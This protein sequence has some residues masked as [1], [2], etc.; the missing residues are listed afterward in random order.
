MVQKA[1]TFSEKLEFT[2]QLPW[3]YAKK[4]PSYHLSIAD[5]FGHPV[6]VGLEEGSDVEA[7]N[8]VGHLVFK[9]EKEAELLIRVKTFDIQFSSQKSPV[10]LIVTPNGLEH[11][12]IPAHNYDLS[13]TL[14]YRLMITNKVHVVLLDTVLCG[15]GD[16]KFPTQLNLTVQTTDKS[17]DDYFNQFQYTATLEDSA[18]YICTKSFARGNLRLCLRHI[19]DIKKHNLGLDFYRLSVEGEEQFRLDQAEELLKKVIAD[20][21]RLGTYTAGT[22]EFNEIRNRMRSDADSALALY[23]YFLKHHE[24]LQ[25][26]NPDLVKIFKLGLLQNTYFLTI[27]TGDYVTAKAMLDLINSVCY[28]FRGYVRTNELPPYIRETVLSLRDWQLKKLLESMQKS[29]DL[30]GEDY[31][32]R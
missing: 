4:S 14:N 2:S 6:T 16:F 21:N 31:L 29:H 11:R 12:R 13:Y 30:V 23:A 26:E 28:N 10:L 20:F 7:W 27:L 15:E 18:A 22:P 1:T 32:K 5:Q 9:P 8:Y 19:L 17:L 25:S 24:A 3:K